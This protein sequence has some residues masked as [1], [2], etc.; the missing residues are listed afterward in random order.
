MSK[1]TQT[2]TLKLIYPRYKHLSF[3]LVQTDLISGSTSDQLLKTTAPH[4][5]NIYIWGLNKRIAKQNF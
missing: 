1:N 5:H 3:Q 2:S 4:F